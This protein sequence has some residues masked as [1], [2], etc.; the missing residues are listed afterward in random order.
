GFGDGW[1]DNGF[2]DADIQ[3]FVNSVPV[4]NFAVPLGATN[5]TYLIAVNDGDVV[6]AVYNNP[7]NV[8]NNEH[9]FELLD[10]SGAVVASAVQPSDTDSF[11]GFVVAGCPINTVPTMTEWGLFLFALGMATLGLV[12]VYNK[13][14]QLA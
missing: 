4:G 10:N 1:Q 6:D 5:A 3:V 2:E 8:F 9:A 7:G 11:N 12:F 13:Q 14:R